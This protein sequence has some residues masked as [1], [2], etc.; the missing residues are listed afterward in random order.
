MLYSVSDFVRLTQLDRFGL[1]LC[2]SVIAHLALVLGI[3]FVMPRM[4]PGDVPP[5]NLDVTLVGAPSETRPEEAEFL[6]EFDHEGGG[7]EPAQRSAR[8]FVSGATRPRAAS[9]A[10][11]ATRPA[12]TVSVMLAPGSER[13]DAAQVPSER[14]SIAS[15][16]APPRAGLGADP[17]AGDG[18]AIALSELAALYPRQK[19]LSAATRESRFASY[20]DL[21]RTRVEQVGNRNF[22][23]EVRRRQLRGSLI[24]DV[25]LFSDG[26]VAHVAVLRSSGDPVLDAAAVDIV[27]LAEPY[28][29]F[30]ADFRHDIDVLH[31][32]R[33]W[34]FLSSNRIVSQD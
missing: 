15:A 23:I 13:R 9:P 28:A 24:L 5:A 16:A 21:W 11:P 1:S 33:T 30:P 12:A 3:S 6:A 18:E 32:T 34:E 22:P 26:S 4:N 31:I 7:A 8:A 10:A 17:L 29:P 14:W 2:G 27:W 25:A 19:Y 20:M